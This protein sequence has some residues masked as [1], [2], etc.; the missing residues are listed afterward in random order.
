VGDDLD[1]NELPPAVTVQ[2][3]SGPLMITIP[4]LNSATLTPRA[5]QA[6]KTCILLEILF[7]YPVNIDMASEGMNSFWRGGIE[8]LEKE[9]E[10]YDIL[11]EST[12][13]NLNPVVSTEIETMLVNSNVI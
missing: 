2:A 4:P 8:N 12:E 13:E 3:P 9:M 6:K 7:D 5:T 1:E 10:A 11:N